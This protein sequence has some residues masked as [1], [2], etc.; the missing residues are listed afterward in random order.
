M[1][2]KEKSPSLS[3][4]LVVGTFGK[5][6]IVS[7]TK[8][9]LLCLLYST[10]QR[11]SLSTSDKV[12]FFAKKYSSNSNL[13]DLGI[14]LLLFPSRTNRK[15][16]NISVTPMMVKKVITDLDSSK[17]SGPDCIPLVFLKKCKPDISYLLAKLFNMFL[18]E[19]CFPDCWKVSM[20]LPVF[21][22]VGERST[23]KNYRWVSFLVVVVKVF[24]KLAHNRNINHLEKYGLFLVS[25]MV[26]SRLNQL[27]FF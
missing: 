17:T 22:N 8:V 27:Q 13:D 16:H 24:G 9:D 21:K 14:S 5:L 23:A 2:I 18:K 4:N 15:L 11:C 10:T 6:L 25:S 3:R 26:L 1:L 12:K 20:V 19:P 7:S